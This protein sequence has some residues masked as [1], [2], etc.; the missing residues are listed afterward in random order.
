MNPE[1]VAEIYGVVPELKETRRECPKQESPDVPPVVHEDVDAER[2]GEKDIGRS[3][4]HRK[5]QGKPGERY[6]TSFCAPSH[7][8][9][10]GGCQGELACAVLPEGLAAFAEAA[11]AQGVECCDEEGTAAACEPS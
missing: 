3:G 7:Q 4:D 10:E 5:R 6:P 1:G 8:T 11:R 2:K 9:V